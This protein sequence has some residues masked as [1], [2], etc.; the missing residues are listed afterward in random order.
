[1]LAT[2][3]QTTILQPPSIMAWPIHLIITLLASDFFCM[4][5]DQKAKVR[6]LKIWLLKQYYYLLLQMMGHDYT[7]DRKLPLSFSFCIG[8]TVLC[9]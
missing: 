7:I 4:I 1:M 8:C 5:L 9:G 2:V 3:Q 6:E